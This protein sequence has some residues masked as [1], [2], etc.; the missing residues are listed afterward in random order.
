MAQRLKNPTRIHEDAGSI[1]GLAQ[2]KLRIQDCHELWYRSQMWLGSNVAKAVVQ[3]CSYSS[4]WTPSLGI[5][6]CRGHSPKK[7]KKK[8]K[9]EDFG[10]SVVAQQLGSIHEEAGLIPGLSQWVKD[11]ALP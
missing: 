2:L 9:P 6:I 1:P 8:K 3:A 7:Q 10:V 4:N 11:P 5:S